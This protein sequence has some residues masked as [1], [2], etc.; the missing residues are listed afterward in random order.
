MDVLLAGGVGAVVG[1]LGSFVVA[2]IQ[3]TA[4]RARND[5][6]IRRG[7]APFKD[8]VFVPLWHLFAIIGLVAGMSWTWRLGDP[9]VTGTIAGSALPALFAVAW[10]ATLLAQ[11]RR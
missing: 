5:R 1:F 7:E 4:K 2:T 3:I 6:L 8:V 11:F 10:L 9:W